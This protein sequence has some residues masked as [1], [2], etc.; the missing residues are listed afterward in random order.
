M[1][2]QTFLGPNAFLALKLRTNDSTVGLTGL[3]WE[4]LGDLGHAASGQWSLRYLIFFIIHLCHKS[5]EG[6]IFNNL[7]II[8]NFLKAF[9]PLN[10]PKLCLVKCQRSQLTKISPRLFTQESLST[11]FL[12]LSLYHLGADMEWPGFLL[13][14][15]SSKM[16]MNFKID[17]LP[18]ILTFM[19]F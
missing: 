17:L 3:D 19:T 4:L 18:Y 6:L 7:F 1:L 16:E 14:C 15:F 12:I 8:Y 5:K 2:F 10:F 11:L 13:I 9:C